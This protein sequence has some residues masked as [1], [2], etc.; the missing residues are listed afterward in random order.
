MDEAEEVYHRYLTLSPHNANAIGNLAGLLLATGRSD[1][2]LELLN[3]ALQLV[4]SGDQASLLVELWYYAFAHNPG[5]DR[6]A[7]LRELRVLLE[8][9]ERSLGWDL[10]RNA[11]RAKLEHHPDGEWLDSL[12]AVISEGQSLAMLTTWS[13]WQAAVPTS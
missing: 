3:K 10:S 6:V 4:T 12:A 8:R 1:E 7:A 13:V 2:G 11:K 9:G 5:R